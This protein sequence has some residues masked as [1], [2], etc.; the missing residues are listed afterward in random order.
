VF[1]H[2]AHWSELDPILAYRLLALRSAVFVVE[3]ECVYPD[4]DGRDLEP[5]AEHWWMTEGERVVAYLR[6]LTEP[7]EDGSVRRIGRVVTD[8]VARGRGLA[9]VT[10][11]AV[12]A[13]HPDSEFVLSGQ[14]HLEDWYA[15]LG[16]VPEG[17]PYLEDG[18]PH[19][20]MRR[21]TEGC[22]N[23]RGGRPISSG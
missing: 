22:R 19:V 23:G 13:A 7:G 9:R 15:G 21:G 16:F 14:S 5:D 20:F 2:H 12:L 11:E 8:P 10:M 3:Q 1:L 4:L 6:V 17:E 18:I